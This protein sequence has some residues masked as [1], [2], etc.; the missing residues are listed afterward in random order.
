MQKSAT[1]N[2]RVDSDVKHS[3]EAVPSQVAPPTAVDIVLGQ[4]AMIGRVP[5]KVPLP[6]A[7]ASANA[8]EM[9]GGEMLERILAVLAKI[10]AAREFRLRKPGGCRRRN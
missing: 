2:A 9:P 10:E 7:P 8:D 6:G 1:L 3:A 5:F 4:V